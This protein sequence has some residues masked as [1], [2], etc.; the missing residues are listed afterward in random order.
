MQKM[1]HQLALHN[2]MEA[3]LPSK[4]IVALPLLTQVMN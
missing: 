1:D 3:E 4:S 2:G